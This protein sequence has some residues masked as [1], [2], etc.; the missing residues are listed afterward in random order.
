VDVVGA[1]RRVHCTLAGAIR[2]SMGRSQSKTRA[3]LLLAEG[4][5]A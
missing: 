4:E 5:S 1:L 2:G 3:W